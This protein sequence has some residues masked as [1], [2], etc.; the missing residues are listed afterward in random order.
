MNSA[1][2]RKPWL[3]FWAALSGISIS[4]GPALAQNRCAVLGKI[5]EGREPLA[6]GVNAVKLTIYRGGSLISTRTGVDL[7]VGDQLRGLPGLQ[8]FEIIFRNGDV[9]VY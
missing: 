8:S 5:Y 3:A 6:A 1:R 2:K 4:C 7:L 9:G